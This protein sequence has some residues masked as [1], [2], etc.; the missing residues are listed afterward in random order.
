MAWI[1]GDSGFYMDVFPV[2]WDRWLRHVDDRLPPDLDPLCPRI[3]TTLEQAQ[4]FAQ[5]LG[6]RIPSPAEFAAAWGSA[7]FP[8]GER[9]NPREGRVGQPRYGALPEVG[10]HPP[11]DR[12][13]FDLGAWLWQW[14]NDG[15]IAG[16]GSA[17][18]GPVILVKP[19]EHAQIGIRMVRDP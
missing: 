4:T 19:P 10:L 6:K 18:D 11:S 1:P 17:P 12:G 15:R 14:L 3:E 13:L 16:G 5:R 9:P 7:P 2:T 8:W